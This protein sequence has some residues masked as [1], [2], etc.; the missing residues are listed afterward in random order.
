MCTACYTIRAVK[1]FISLDTP[2]FFLLFLLLLMNYGIIF[3][4]N[5]S[6]SIRV[7]RLQKRVVRII[8]VSRQREFCIELFGKLKIWPFQSQYTFS[9]WLFI[10]NSKDQYKLNSDIHSINTRQKSNLYQS[11]S[12]LTMYRKWT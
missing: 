11:L 4:G 7:L 1:P 12:S 5:S 6:H 3:W 8:T 2:V 10:V 9:L